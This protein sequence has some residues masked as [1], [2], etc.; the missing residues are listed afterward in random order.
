M[1]NKKQIFRQSN[2][3][4]QERYAAGHSAAV[5]YLRPVSNSFP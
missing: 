1:T 2:A 5:F 3:E 4:R